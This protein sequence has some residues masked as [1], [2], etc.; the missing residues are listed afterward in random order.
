MVWVTLANHKEVWRTTQQAEPSQEEVNHFLSYHNNTRMDL[1]AEVATLSIKTSKASQPTLLWSASS[2]Q[3]LQPPREEGHSSS[4]SSKAS[5][6]HRSPS[7]FGRSQESCTSNQ[8]C[9]DFLEARQPPDQHHQFPA[10]E[11][12][13]LL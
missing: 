7:P 11:E 8:G 5:K 6:Q 2:K 13:L 3:Y 10:Q 1:N 12:N 9:R 4:T